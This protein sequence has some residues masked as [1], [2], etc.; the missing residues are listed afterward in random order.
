MNPAAILA[1]KINHA[2]LIRGEKTGLIGE[3][4]YR[5]KAEAGLKR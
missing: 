4:I 1:V 5:Y 3:S 2:N